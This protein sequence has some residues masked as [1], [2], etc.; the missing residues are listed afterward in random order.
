PD[1]PRP[2]SPRRR[3]APR[4][5]LPRPLRPCCASASASPRRPPRPWARQ[6]CACASASP[7]REP[8]RPSWRRASASPRRELPRPSSSS[9]SSSRQPFSGGPLNRALTLVLD[10]QNPCDLALC[11]P[12][13]RRVL[14]RTGRGLEAQVEELLPRLRESLLQLVVGQ[15]AQLPRPH[16]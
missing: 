1:R 15:V 10:R 9:S 8:R 3:P 4:Q 13:A 14:E 11:Q 2:R 5:A 7:P 16:G 6:P 12:Q